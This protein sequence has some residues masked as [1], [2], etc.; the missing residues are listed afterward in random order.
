MTTNIVYYPHSVVA[1]SAVPAEIFSLSQLSDV[2][3]GHNF[4]DLT[5][6]V[7]SLSAPQFSGTHQAAPDNRFTVKQIKSVLDACIAGNLSIARDLSAGNVDVEYKAGSNLNVRLAGSAVRARMQ[8][9]AM[10]TWES[11]TCRQGQL[12]EIRCRLAA[13][14]KSSTGNDPLVFT[15]G[16]TVAA[17]VG[18]QHL[19]TQ[20][21]VKLNGSFVPGV[22]DWT[23]DNNIEYEEEA[24][25][26]DGFLTYLG[27]KRFRPVLTLHTRDASVLATYGS[28]GTALTAFKSFLRKKL[29]SNINI[30]DATQENI[31]IGISGG[32]G[33]TIKAR[34]ISSPTAVAE[35]TVDLI[36][37]GQEAL[38]A[39]DTTA[40]VA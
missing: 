3:V 31:E 36:Y 23:L 18:L 16:L 17:T 39:I 24:S 8:E 32:A 34:K 12:A 30:L 25:D 2:E 35:V 26:G 29:A 6:H 38:Y 11:I 21:P 40:A 15:G 19:F 22:T 33:G 10:L 9:N 14:Y 4:Q 28:R 5:E 27:V 1:Y 37:N 13:I 20:G 7:P